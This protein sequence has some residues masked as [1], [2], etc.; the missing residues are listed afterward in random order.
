[1]MLVFLQIISPSSSELAD[2]KLVNS[3]VYKTFLNNVLKRQAPAT[4]QSDE[5]SNRIVKDEK[6]NESPYERVIRNLR[7]NWEMPM[8]Y[9]QERGYFNDLD[10]R[11][12]NSNNDLSMDAYNLINGPLLNP[13]TSNNVYPIPQGPQRSNSLLSTKTDR[14][15]RSFNAKVENE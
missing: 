9:L 2:S 14:S 13:S 6:Y 12:D 4:Q 8:K 11:K 15:D 1:M 3:E 5:S 7:S 10:L